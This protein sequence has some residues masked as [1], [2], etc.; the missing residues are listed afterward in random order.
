M[1]IWKIPHNLHGTPGYFQEYHGKH[2]IVV[3]FWCIFKWDFSTMIF[4]NDTISVSR[5]STLFFI[6]KHESLKQDLQKHEPCRS[7]NNMILFVFAVVQQNS[8][9]IHF[10]LLW[11]IKGVFSRPALLPTLLFNCPLIMMSWD[12]KYHKDPS[13]NEPCERYLIFPLMWEIWMS[14]V[15]IISSMSFESLWSGS[16]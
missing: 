4:P 8:N 7:E 2:S 15:L 16:Y 13:R 12:L 6:Q 1:V 11:V 9:W 14:G 10:Y 3:H 5:S